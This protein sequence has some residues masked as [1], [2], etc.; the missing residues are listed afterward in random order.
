MRA[1]V[2]KYLLGVRYKIWKTLIDADIQGKPENRELSSPCQPVLFYIW[3]GR[4]MIVPYY[5]VFPVWPPSKKTWLNTFSLFIIY[6]KSP[7]L[8]VWMRRMYMF[9]IVFFTI[10][11][12]V[13]FREESE[14]VVYSDWLFLEHLGIVIVIYSV[15]Y[16]YVSNRDVETTSHILSRFVTNSYMICFQLV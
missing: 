7:L 16:V 8:Y 1:I 4:T 2:Y 10:A 13:V 9:H 11:I 15:F 6:T 5:R 3:A 14:S 12:N